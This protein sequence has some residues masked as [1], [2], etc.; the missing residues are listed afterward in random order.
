VVFDH[1]DTVL[2]GLPSLLFKAVVGLHD[3]GIWLYSVDGVLDVAGEI[4]Q[5][6]NTTTLNRLYHYDVTKEV[7]KFFLLV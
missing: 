7:Y 1:M 2:S 3:H 5:L 4:G 6:R